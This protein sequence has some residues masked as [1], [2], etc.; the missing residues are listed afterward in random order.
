MMLGFNSIVVT[1]WA[2]MLTTALVLIQSQ[3]ERSDERERE[4][5]EGRRD[6]GRERERDG[7]REGD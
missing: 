1:C 6:G 7:G 2:G 4:R 5:E 3:R